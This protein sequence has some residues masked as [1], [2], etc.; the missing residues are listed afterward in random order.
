MQELKP[1]VEGSRGGYGIAQWTGPRRV[2]FES[3]AEA[4]ELPLDSYEANYGNLK[5]ELT[6]TGEAKVIAKLKD[7]DDPA[8]A[9]Q[10]FTST[11]L[12]PGV[13]AMDSRVARASGYMEEDM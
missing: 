7:V 5:R 6:E 4:N 11:F 12:R 9:A 13:V 10:I 8:K 1:V 3:W 2:E